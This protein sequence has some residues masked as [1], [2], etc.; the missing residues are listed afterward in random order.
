MTV[1]RREDVQSRESRVGTAV[2]IALLA[3]PILAIVPLIIRRLRVPSLNRIIMRSPMGRSCAYRYC[4]AAGAGCSAA[5]RKPASSRAIATA[6][7]G[8]GA[9]ARGC[10][11]DNS[12][13]V[14]EVGASADPPASSAPSLTNSMAECAFHRREPTFC[15]TSR[16]RVSV[17]VVPLRSAVQETQCLPS[18]ALSA[19]P[20]GASRLFIANLKWRQ[21]TTRAIGNA[22]NCR[23]FSRV[24]PNYFGRAREI[25]SVYARFRGIRR[26]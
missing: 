3:P 16:I 24:C 12:S 17:D 13:F 7:F 15:M 25:G 14:D 10:S 9:A 5:H 21:S 4:T 20:C 8:L 23:S 26:F 22:W 18:A 19:N 11:A 1:L 6:I 2:R